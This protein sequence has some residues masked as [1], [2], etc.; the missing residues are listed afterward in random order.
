M[1]RLEAV[2][3]CVDYADYLAETLPFLLPHVDDVVV[4]T[5]PEDGRT[6]RVCKRHGVRFLPTRCFYRE[7]EPSTRPAGSTTGWPTSSSTA[8]CSTSMRTSSCRRAR[9]TCSATSDL[10]PRKLYG[11]DRVNCVG[12]AAWDDLKADPEVQYEWSCLVKPP[13]RWPLGARIAHMEYGGYCPIGFFQLWNPSGSG[14]SPVSPRRPG[15]GRALRRAPCHPVGPPGPLPHPRIDL[16]PPGDEGQGR[17]PP[18][19]TELVGPH[20]SGVHPG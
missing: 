5:T 16:H 20:D 19:G 15:D 4:V 9:G 6:H 3:I 14:V 7:G 13:R 8:G 11:C 12:R 2:V 10:D 1:N 18:D 17:S